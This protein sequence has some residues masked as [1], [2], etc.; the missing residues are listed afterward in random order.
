METGDVRRMIPT[1]SGLSTY[2][3][4]P[5]YSSRRGGAWGLVLL[6][7]AVVGSIV[8]SVQL[9][10]YKVSKDS[11]MEMEPCNS[12]PYSFIADTHT[13]NGVQSWGT[14]N[15]INSRSS[16]PSDCLHGPCFE[17]VMDSVSNNVLYMDSINAFR[18]IEPLPPGREY[19]ADYGDDW[20]QLHLKPTPL[21]LSVSG[22]SLDLSS[23]AKE[24]SSLSIAELTRLGQSVVNSLLDNHGSFARISDC[25]SLGWSQAMRVRD[26]ECT[27]RRSWRSQT[28]RCATSNLAFICGA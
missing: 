18:V 25:Q 8:A 1:L 2:N 13:Y 10:G 20:E 26:H 23:E 22:P 9:R 11:D 15:L 5:T 6:R 24:L 12:S 14:G 28:H 17:T 4:L 27:C 7:G 3:A 16:R 21:S 19:L